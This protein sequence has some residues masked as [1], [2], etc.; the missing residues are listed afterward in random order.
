MSV[1]GCLLALA[2]GQTAAASRDAVLLLESSDRE[3]APFEERLAAEL[4]ATGFEVVLEP[5]HIDASKDVPEQ[6]WLLCQWRGTLAVLWVQPRADGRVDAWVADRAT[7]KAM[8]RTF[9]A[10]TTNTERSRLALRAVELLHASLL[11]LRLMG[12]SEKDPVPEATLE[13]VKSRFKEPERGAHWVFGTGLGLLV[14][15]GGVGPQP[16]FEL[17][18]GYAFTEWLTAELQAVTSVFPSQVSQPGSKADVGA[19]FLRALAAWTPL[20]LGGFA[21]GLALG[22]GGALVWATGDT[23][24]EILAA[25]TDARALWLLSG[26]LVLGMRLSDGVRLQLLACAGAWLP[27]VGVRFVGEQAAVLGTPVIDALLRLEFR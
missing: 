7:Q 20:R 16:T 21:A 15:P 2:L 4:A 11:E 25:Q 18:L 10:P 26:G 13:A 12:P 14:T 9:D 1:L 17:Q 5:T 3:W 27:E 19:V 24:S 23:S 6:L 22:T 8:L